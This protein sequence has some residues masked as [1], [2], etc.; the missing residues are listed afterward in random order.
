VGACLRRP[1]TDQQSVY[2][3][4]VITTCPPVKPMVLF[5]V[6]I[7]LH[8]HRLRSILGAA[9]HIILTP[10][11]QLMEELGPYNSE[12]QSCLLR[13]TEKIASLCFGPSGDQTP[14]LLI[15]SQPLIDCTTGSGLGPMI[16]L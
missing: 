9:G 11:N 2:L 6:W 14:Y 3:H 1:K 10:A 5:L 16:S 7:L 8:A 12:Q 4:S 13:W 15:R